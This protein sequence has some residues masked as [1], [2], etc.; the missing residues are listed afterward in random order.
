MSEDVRHSSRGVGGSAEQR[1]P[2]VYSIISKSEK[3][4]AQFKALINDY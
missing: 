4:S 3:Y 1:S 2:D